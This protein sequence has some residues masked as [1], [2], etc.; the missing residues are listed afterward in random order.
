MAGKGHS[1]HDGMHAHLSLAWIQIQKGDAVLIL[2]RYA[3][4]RIRWRNEGRVEEEDQQTENESSPHV[5]GAR[6][7]A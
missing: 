7:G 3:L 1:S 6:L 5:G 4:L 2:P